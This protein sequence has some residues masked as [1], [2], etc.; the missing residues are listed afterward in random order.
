MK[1][2]RRKHP[3]RLVDSCKRSSVN[4]MAAGSRPPRSSHGFFLLPATFSNTPY[5]TN[6]FVS[7]VF[8]QAV[9]PGVIQTLA[10]IIIIKKMNYRGYM[11]ADGYVVISIYPLEY[12]AVLLLIWPVCR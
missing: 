11:D 8:E 7:N 1:I 12:I 4:R 9:G 6:V 2:T 10:L 5:V 3:D